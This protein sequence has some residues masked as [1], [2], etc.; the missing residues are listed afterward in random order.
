MDDSTLFELAVSLGLEAF[1]G[2]LDLERFFA[3]PQP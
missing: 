3:E 2:P 1:E